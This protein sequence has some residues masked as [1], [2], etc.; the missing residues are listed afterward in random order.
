MFKMFLFIFMKFTLKCSKCLN[1]E[2]SLPFRFDLKQLIVIKLIDMK[3]NQLLHPCYCI[4]QRW[5]ILDVTLDLCTQD[6]PI[7][8]SL[9]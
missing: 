9:N 3:K 4:P 8:L 5:T 7:K 1:N 6:S 2:N